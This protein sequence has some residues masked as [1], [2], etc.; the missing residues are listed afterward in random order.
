MAWLE[1]AQ[2]PIPAGRQKSDK[3]N[4]FDLSGD[5]CVG[6]PL[7]TIFDAGSKPSNN[8]RAKRRAQVAAIAQA[9]RVAHTPP[10][11]AGEPPRRW[12]RSWL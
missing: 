10:T 4:R 7:K 12:S 8:G 9:P 5:F 2:L 1:R 11:G 6:V 3:G